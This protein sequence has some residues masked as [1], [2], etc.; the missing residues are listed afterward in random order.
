MCAIFFNLHMF[1]SCV[2]VCVF[3]AYRFFPLL[4]IFTVIIIALFNRDFGPMLSAEKV[5][6]ESAR[7]KRV[8]LPISSPK[9]DIQHRKKKKRSLCADDTG[10]PAEV[11]DSGDETVELKGRV[12]TP[13]PEVEPEY[14]GE[15][16]AGRDS[17][18]MSSKSL[19]WVLYQMTLSQ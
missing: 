6:A 7:L 5:S 3:V 10:S 4:L 19:F 18:S 11:E 9:N 16:I 15:A 8:R 12:T 14:T 1:F 13:R 2:Y 17:T